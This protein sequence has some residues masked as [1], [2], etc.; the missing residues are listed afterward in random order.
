MHIVET[1]RALVVGL[2]PTLQRTLVV[3]RLVPNTVHRARQARFDVAGK[4][5]NVARVL[6][7]L[8]E[9]ATHLCHAGGDNR[10]VWRTMCHTDRINL[11]SPVAPA[12][13][14]TCTT[15]L[16][17]ETGEASE[18]VEPAG[19]V[20]ERCAAAVWEAFC[21]EIKRHNVLLL[22]GSAAPG[23]ERTLYATM[24]RHARELHIPVGIDVHSV[25]LKEVIVEKPDLVKVN[26]GEFGDVFT[27]ELRDTLRELEAGGRA[28]SE[29]PAA[30]RVIERAVRRIE[31]D[32][33]RVVLSQGAQ[34]TLIFD[35][36]RA[37][38]IQVE[39]IRLE[40]VNPIGC[41]DVMFAALATR[42]FTGEGLVGAVEFS[43]TMAAINATLLKPGTV[44][45]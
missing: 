35:H 11:I 6:G 28:L 2:N 27:P 22:C 3:E 10:E 7:Q 43:H 29:D 25:A 15:I 33:T 32:G 39:T 42:L 24:A 36:E 23:Y 17:H 30:W 37:K 31:G 45:T 21:R 41:G 19:E 38:L 18:F 12:R 44:R 26:V 20:D 5:A 1:F 16:D 40:P 34:P 9:E 13:V 4:G 14:R 8:G